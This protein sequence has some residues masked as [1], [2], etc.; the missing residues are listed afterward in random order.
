MIS[1]L[2]ERKGS[3]TPMHHS[4]KNMFSGR[5][6]IARPG[7][8]RRCE[9]SRHHPCYGSGGLEKAVR[10]DRKHNDVDQE[11]LRCLGKDERI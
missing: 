11:R 8:T 7:V 5:P 6:G 2:M 3:W 10:Y 1:T 4:L 9:D